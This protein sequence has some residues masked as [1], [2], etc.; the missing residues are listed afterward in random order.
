MCSSIC[1]F[2]YPRQCWDELCKAYVWYR[3]AVVEE[4]AT[5]SIFV[6]WN[7]LTFSI[8]QVLEIP[9]SI[10]SASLSGGGNRL[11]DTRS[12]PQNSTTLTSPRPTPPPY[13]KQHGNSL[14][15]TDIADY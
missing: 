15:Y 11:P 14:P 12:G 8:F 3:A 2:V 10:C 5:E 9:Q 13:R 4:V 1:D 6:E 7:S